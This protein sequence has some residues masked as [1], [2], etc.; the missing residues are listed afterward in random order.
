MKK[1]AFIIAV[2]C[3]C[4][5]SAIH[6][7]QTASRVLLEGVVKDADSEKPVAMAT[8]ALKEIGLWG[9]TDGEGHFVLKNIPA[10]RYTLEISLL[11][12]EISEFPIDLTKNLVG[13]EWSIREQSLKLQEVVLVASGGKGMNSSSRIGQQALEHVQPSSIKDVLQ[14]LPGNLT[15]NPSLNTV[16]K[17]TIREIK[18]NDA[19][20]SLGTAIIVDGAAMSNDANMQVLKSGTSTTTDA[21]TSVASTAG[22]G[23]DA[24][25]IATDNIES[26]EVIRGI[27]SVEYGN[28]TSGAVIV[29]TKAG[30]TPWEV[31]F[32]AD[33]LLKQM[34]LGKGL[35][36]GE[37]A[38]AL[39]F[40]V[41]YSLSYED[42]RTPAKS[43]NRINTQVGYSNRFKKTT[44]NARLSAIYSNADVKDD[45]DNFLGNISTERNTG[46]HLNI[47]GR[48][49]INKSWITNVEYLVAGNVSKQYSREKKYRSPGRMP[50]ST[51]LESGENVGFFTLPQYYSDVT[52]DGLPIDFQSKLTANLY[53]KYG[54]VLNKVLI[55]AEWNT[56]GNEG[57]GKQFNP[58][59]PPDAGGNNNTLRERSY[60]DIPYLNRYTFF[61]EDKVN[62]PIGTTNLEI[63]AGVR[64]NSILPNDKF[65]MDELTAW[66]PRINMRYTI[67]EKPEGFKELSIRG[68]WGLDY[69]MPSMIYLYPEPAYLDKV[70]YSY[71]DID[72]NGYGLAVFTTKRV[73][74][75]SNPELKLQKSRKVEIGTDFTIGNVSGSVVYYNEKLSNGY[76]F[77]TYYDPFYYTRYGYQLVNGV[78]TEVP[79]PSGKQPVYSNGEILVDGAP[80][81]KISDTTFI[82]Y[83]VPQNSIQ[84]SKW[85]I[86][87]TLDLGTLKAINTSINIDGAYM[88]IRRENTALTSLLPS[89]TINNKVYSFVGI[90]AGS[91]G[92]ATGSIDERL[93]TNVRF[94]THIP[95]IRMVVTLGVQ[96]VFLDRSRNISEYNG[97]VLPYYTDNN[98]IRHTGEAV[99]D[100]TQYTKFVDPVYVMDKNGNQLTLAQAQKLYPGFNFSEQL[101]HET[102]M[103]T[104]Y[105]RQSY[106]FYAM[107][108]L[109]VTKELG[110][111]ATVSFYANNFLNMLGRVENSVTHYPQNMNSPIYFGAEVKLSF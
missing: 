94:I 24:R 26:I 30:V 80:L 21:T 50:M 53:G 51:S 25:Q 1:V 2:L 32:K 36:L 107:L 102:N 105:L 41:D 54:N 98:G 4:G 73:D 109:R 29:K 27:A 6:A 3:M 99:Y 92:M 95:K 90:Y 82:S 56:Q 111:I 14:L 96:M 62:F 28:M 63:Q 93:N 103:A 79:V 75:T 16:N 42:P 9:A 66:E 31:R 37:K 11:G 40:N 23:I 70:S 8:I 12:Y 10:G 33:P 55:G 108:N 43:Y 46:V 104:Y 85:G 57:E 87:Y 68:G 18:T 77:S 58:Y 72:A 49:M 45:P 15:Q 44:F 65:K 91:V 13:G 60:K 34:A 106:P 47:N 76:G 7:Q 89:T 101:T 61:V 39:N 100:D 71:N 86:E 64:M 48:W 69:K 22:S 59:Y 78:P 83:S 74:K 81:P 19:T 67:L 38:G 5:S 35:R 88:C 17:L 52:I 84:Q 20:N 97:K 110:N